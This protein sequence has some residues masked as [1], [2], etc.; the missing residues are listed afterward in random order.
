MTFDVLSLHGN[1]YQD[2]FDL[3]LIHSEQGEMVI[4]K[5]HIPIMLHIKEGHLELRQQQTKQFI[6]LNQATIEFH[7]NHLTV[8]SYEAEIGNSVDEA[9]E[10]SLKR[11]KDRTEEAKSE[12]IDFSKL[13]KDLF[14]YLKKTKAGKLS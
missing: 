13:E 12:N 9:K 2:T 1:H 3:V 4:L 10:V 7:D 6:Y 5:D 8:V 11:V 14:D